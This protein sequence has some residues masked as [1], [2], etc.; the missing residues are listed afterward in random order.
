[1]KRTKYK[2]INY[3]VKI[4]HV[5]V[6][7]GKRDHLKRSFKKVDKSRRES[8]FGVN[9]QTQKPECFLHFRNRHFCSLTRINPGNQDREKLGAGSI[10]M[11]DCPLC[12]W[13]ST[14]IG[15]KEVTCAV[16][17]KRYAFS[18]RRSTTSTG[19]PRIG[20]VRRGLVDATN[21]TGRNT[22]AAEKNLFLPQRRLDSAFSA[23]G[24]VSFFTPIEERINK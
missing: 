5:C 10:E 23:I 14:Y 4:R 18:A 3:R 2:S 21:V 7:K 16:Y 9:V 19:C 20:N 12:A 17:G 13:K 8:M 24:S 22:P 1:M 15:G 6:R 11:A